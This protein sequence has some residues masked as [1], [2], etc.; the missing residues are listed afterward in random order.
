MLYLS[1]KDS[2]SSSSQC[3]EN[4]SVV[5]WCTKSKFDDFF[6]IMSEYQMTFYIWCR[7]SKKKKIELKIKSFNFSESM[8]FTT[9]RNHC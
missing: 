8:Y 7:S 4:N 2:E 1:D 9:S 3:S 6:V 5:Y